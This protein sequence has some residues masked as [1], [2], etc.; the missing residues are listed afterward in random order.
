VTQ[1]HGSEVDRTYLFH[2]AIYQW[3]SRSR[4][5]S[6]LYLDTVPRFYMQNGNILW[7]QGWTPRWS[8]QLSFLGVD[9]ITYSRRQGVRERLAPSP[10]K[11]VAARANYATTPLSKWEFGFSDGRRDVD[12]LSRAEF[13]I[14]AERNQFWS[15]H[16]DIFGKLGGRKNFTSDDIFSNLYL[17]YY[18]RKWEL[19]LDA[20]YGVEKY[21]DGV[22]K[23]P[24]TVEVDISNYLSRAL[25]LTGSVQQAQD[26]SVRILSG[27]L[28]LG[29]RFGGGDPPPLRDGSPP[30]GQL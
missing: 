4:L 1:S 24:L 20:E 2:N 25:F 8:S 10:Y 11:E 14:G 29:Y 19:G 9:V 18:T 23:H 17:G 16:W 12:R 3:N 22:T 5:I 30:R 27:F 7:Q 6:L 15:R 21:R 28:R 13:Y 26:E